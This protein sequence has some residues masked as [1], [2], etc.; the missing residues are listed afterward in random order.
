MQIVQQ[1]QRQIAPQQYQK[2]VQQYKPV[3]EPPPTTIILRPEAPVSQASPPVFASQP[4]TA[5]LRGTIYYD[6]YDKESESIKSKRTLLLSIV[7]AVDISS[8]I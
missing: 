5:T 2:P 3:C 8:E 7:I 6:K 4:A 1:Q